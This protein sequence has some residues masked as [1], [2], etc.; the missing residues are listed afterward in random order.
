M[1]SILYNIFSFILCL[2]VGILFYFY[3]YF[4]KRKEIDL[5]TYFKEEK[6]RFTISIIL[7]LGFIS[8]TFLID[9]FPGGLNQ[10]EASAGYEAYAIM[11]SG[12]DRNGM[13]MPVHFIAWGSGQNVLYSYLMIPFIGVLGLNV[14]SIR[15]PMA[16][17]GCGSIYLIYKFLKDYFDSKAA[18]IGLIFIIIVPWHF[19]K[20]RWGLESNIFPDLILYGVIALMYGIKNKRGGLLIISSVVFGL[21]SYSYGTSYFFL[22]FFIIGVYLYLLITKKVKWYWCVANIGVVAVTALPIIIFVFINLLDKETVRFLWMD[23]PKLDVDRFGAVT[24]IYSGN[25]FESAFENLKTGFKLILTQDDNRVYN[26]IPSFGTLYLIS[27]PFTLI[28]IFRNKSN[29][30]I[31]WIMR[32]WLIVSI[33]M[34]CIVDANVNRIN[35]IY[36]PMIFFTIIGIYEIFGLSKLVERVLAGSYLVY[37]LFFSINYFGFYSSQIANSF[38][39]QFYS[40]MQY[41]MSIEEFNKFY[42]TQ[43]V[44]MPYI[45]ALMESNYDVNEYVENVFFW[46]EG[47]S[48]EKVR[49]FN[50]YYFYLPNN[51]EEGNVYLINKDDHNFDEEDIS[52]YKVTQFENF[53]VINTIIS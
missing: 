39:S 17:I 4:K 51:L 29:K 53:Y 10:D 11:T 25:F 21:S 23:I 2:G 37:F 35:I 36:I 3:P 13:Q 24:N 46:K 26:D 38:Q 15:L 28:G 16:L 50:N 31:A 7:C 6:Y 52:N 30:D 44:N 45:Y 43:R 34:M 40:A 19:M 14:I 33:L 18:L 8:R 49:E 20:S 5:K 41:A 27:L 12:M 48:F 32:I 9:I 42:C 47:I 22:F 1:L